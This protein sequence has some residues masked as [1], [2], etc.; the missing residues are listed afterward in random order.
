[1]VNVFVCVGGT[2]ICK[3]GLDHLMS[4]RQ[5]LNSVNR[6]AADNPLIAFLGQSSNYQHHRETVFP[7]KTN[8][9]FSL[10]GLRGDAC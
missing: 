10:A 6:L 7:V 5:A 8:G 2:L 9:V 1:M 4:R 3:L